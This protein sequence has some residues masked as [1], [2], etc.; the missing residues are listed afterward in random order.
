MNIDL[1]NY[2]KVYE[3][4][5][6]APSCDQL[7]QELSN[8]PWEKHFFLSSEDLRTPVTQSGDKEFDLCYS[9]VA[10]TPYVTQR[11]H[12]AYSKYVTELNFSWFQNWTNFSFMRYHRYAEGQ[13]MA[14]HCDHIYSLFN[15]SERGVPILTCLS[16]LNDG[17]E[18][19]E[20]ILFDDVV[21]DMPKGSFVVFP[22]NFLYPHMVKPVTK[23]V[24][25]SSVS[26]A[27]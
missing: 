7:I 5:L 3:G 23:G 8:E 25:Y 12:D 2:V 24:R 9:N 11:T 1:Q 14:K 18:G 19:G 6:N 4:W 27:W 13:T 20:L 17:Y 21:I 26:W 16:V 15:G 22:A 10:T